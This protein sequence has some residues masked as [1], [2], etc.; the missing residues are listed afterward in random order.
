[1]SAPTRHNYSIDF[2]TLGEAKDVAARF[3]FDYVFPAT[4][5]PMRSQRAQYVADAIGVILADHD[6][7]ATVFPPIIPIEVITER[8]D[9]AAAQPVIQIHTYLD[10]ADISRVYY[11]QKAAMLEL[12][13]IPEPVAV[14][15]DDEEYL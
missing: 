1:M 11:E 14:A 7:Q 13:G 5:G 6:P 3:P 2:L 15:E 8:P 12:T 9:Y 4:E 10:Q